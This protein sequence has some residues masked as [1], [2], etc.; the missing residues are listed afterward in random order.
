MRLN[1]CQ[2]ERLLPQFMQEQA[3]N[4]AIART[5]DPVIKYIDRKSVV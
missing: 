4:V 3:D 2:T 5:L 1:D